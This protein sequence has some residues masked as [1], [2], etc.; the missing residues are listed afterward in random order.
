MISSLTAPQSEG[1]DYPS[2]RF[3]VTVHH[4]KKSGQELRANNWRQ[5]WKPEGCCLLLG[6]SLA[7]VTVLTV[8]AHLPRDATVHRRLHPPL[9]FNSQD[10][11]SQI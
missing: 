4:G 9:L 2:L 8:L 5:E 1:R 6:I 10:K 3:Q 11:A 7:L